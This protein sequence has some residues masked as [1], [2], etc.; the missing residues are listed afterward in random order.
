M[1]DLTCGKEFGE[2]RGMVLLEPVEIDSVG[3]T[4]VGEAS[5][6]LQAA[7]RDD[8]SKRRSSNRNA[9]LL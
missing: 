1:M 6:D 3:G 2:D 4:M 9:P 5:V 7:Q 8:G